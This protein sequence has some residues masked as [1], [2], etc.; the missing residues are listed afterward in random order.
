MAGKC[1]WKLKNINFN[2][3]KKIIIIL[4]C[5][6]SIHCF[7]QAGLVNNAAIVANEGFL[8]PTVNNLSDVPTPLPSGLTISCLCDGMV[9]FW[10]GAS[11]HIFLDSNRIAQIGYLKG[12]DTVSISNRINTNTSNI[13]LRVKYTDTSTMLSGYGT[14]IGLR[15]K[16]TDTA[17]M[18][19]AYRTALNGKQPLITTGTTAQYLRGDLS[20]ATFPTLV[21]TFTNDAGYAL[22]GTS[23]PVTRPIN[24]TTF[25]P[26]TTK[27]AFIKYNIR[28]SCTATIGS[29][30][31]GKVALQHSIDG[32]TTWIDDGEIE[33]SNTVTLAVALNSINVSSGFLVANIPSNALVRMNS[34]NTGTTTITYIRGVET[35]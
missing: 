13:A 12:T 3:M 2:K 14:A 9:H 35:Y 6:F 28:I 16:Y 1:G 8:Y 27:P 31:D 4:L 15:V 5:F 30:S 25:T 18:L 33:N 26:S 10:D 29:A 20:L 7:G 19:S 11:W 23:T 24:S 34:T 21:S 17:A 22:V 32:G